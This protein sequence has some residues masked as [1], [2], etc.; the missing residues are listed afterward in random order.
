MKDEEYKNYLAEIVKDETSLERKLEISES[1]LKEREDKHQEYQDLVD[2][3]SL[4]QEDY[5]KLQAK[6][7]DDFFAYGTSKENTS[8]TEIKDNETEV[9]S[10]DKIV[11]NMIGGN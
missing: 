11:E 9:L 1:L 4:L 10:V 5:R 2:K 6:K 7:V 8:N 3:T